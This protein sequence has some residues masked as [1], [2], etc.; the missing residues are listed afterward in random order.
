MR[1]KDEL[2]IKYQTYIFC[3]YVEIK[4]CSHNMFILLNI[5]GFVKTLFSRSC[6]D[7]VRVSI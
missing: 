1:H 3:A 2:T 6:T 5:Q 4:N 7:E